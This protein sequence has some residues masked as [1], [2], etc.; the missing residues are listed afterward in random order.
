MWYQL[1]AALRESGHIKAAPPASPD[2]NGNG[3]GGKHR[4]AVTDLP[5]ADA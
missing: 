5:A 1:R 3:N 2:R 4:R